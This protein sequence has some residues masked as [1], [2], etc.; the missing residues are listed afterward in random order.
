MVGGSFVVVAPGV[1]RIF[2]AGSFEIQRLIT[3][4]V[5]QNNLE[6]RRSDAILDIGSREQNLLTGLKNKRLLPQ[7]S[8]DATRQIPIFYGS[9][10]QQLTIKNIQQLTGNNV[11]SR[12][13]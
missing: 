13:T 6:D 3:V 1:D 10:C 5:P 12:L 8:L 2:K 4:H 7:L 11:Q 9:T